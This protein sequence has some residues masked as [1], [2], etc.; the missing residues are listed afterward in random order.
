MLTT[1]KYGALALGWAAALL[2]AP[3]AYAA[4]PAPCDGK[5]LITDAAGDAKIK[6][7]VQGTALEDAPAQADILGVF[8]RVD[9]GKVTAN[10]VVNE[11]PE[12]PPEPWR[13]VRYRAYATVGDTTHY[14]EAMLTADGV[15]YTYGHAIPDDDPESLAF[16]YTEDGETTGAVFP[17]KDGIVQIVV[18]A[19][20][21]G[22]VGT[23]LTA[24]SGSFGLMSIPEAP[25]EGQRP[26][27]YNGT[28]TAPDAGADGP[29]VTPAACDAPVE[30]TGS[31]DTPAVP[32]TPPAQTEAP[33]QPPAAAPQPAVASA[34]PLKLTLAKA[35]LSA[36]KAKKA[37]RLTLRSSEALTG[38]RAQ[39]K[40]GSKVLGTASL[41]SVGSTASF[42][43]RLSKAL[44]K[45]AHKLVVSG[46]RADG[47][48]FT[49][50]LKI[51]VRR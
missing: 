25:A 40:R 23:K 5:L 26:P 46:R 48:A 51:S 3:A 33:G 11:L 49:V 14:Y 6:D 32:A 8:Y 2:I 16:T 9:A 4:N 47:S 7:P 30:Q 19:D 35:K 28:D 31:T 39:L 37:A 44:K 1:R 29:A 41:S 27:V 21:G 20:A 50:T 43:V 10:L 38:V 18:P 22:T 45:G 17:G 34:A 24:T 36:K 42:K 13:G 12:A 15:A